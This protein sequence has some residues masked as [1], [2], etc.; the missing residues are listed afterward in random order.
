MKTLIAI[1]AAAT[2][3]ATTNANAADLG[4]AASALG[5]NIAPA[6]TLTSVAGNGEAKLIQV[7]RR[8]GGFRRG[9]RFRRGG[10]FRRLGGFR[11]NGGARRLPRGCRATFCSPHWKKKHR[12]KF[13]KHFKI[14]VYGKVYHGRGC[15]HLKKKWRYTGAYYWKKRYLIC[16]GLY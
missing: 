8:G 1:A 3:F 14:G 13:K 15:Y 12:W 2:L 9:G 7:G 4:G 16:K 11:R 6:T 5:A 10:G